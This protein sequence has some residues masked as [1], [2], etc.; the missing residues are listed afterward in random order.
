LE[1]ASGLFLLLQYTPDW[2]KYQL[3]R[4]NFMAVSKWESRR[5]AEG[6]QPVEASNG[7]YST[8][9]GQ[10]KGQYCGHLYVE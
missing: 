7:Q 4:L 10:A 1:I 2:Q 8:A 3:F 5:G 9:Q 6:H